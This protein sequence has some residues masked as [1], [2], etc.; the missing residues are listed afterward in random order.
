MR[1]KALT[2]VETLREQGFKAYWAGGCVRDL[3]MG[4]EPQDYDIATDAST[5]QIRQIFPKTVPVGAQFGVVIVLMEGDE[6]QVATF[7]GKDPD[8]AQPGGSLFAIH[9]VSPE[10]PWKSE[11]ALDVSL[12]DFTINGLLYD[13]LREKISDFVRGQ[14]D[15]RKG[16]VRAIGDPYAR[17]EEDKLRPMRGVRLAARYR[18]RIEEKTYEAMR[19]YA[20]KILQVSSERVRDEL[21][22]ILTEGHA[23]R[24]IELLQK[25]GL[26]RH[27]LPEVEAMVGVQQPPEHH[28][29]GDVF[30]HTLLALQEL[31]RGAEGPRGKGARGSS[32]PLLPS[33]SAPPPRV[34][35]AMAVLLHDVGK[36][37]TYQENDRITFKGHDKIGAEVALQVCQRLRFS[38][39][40]AERIEALVRD[41][42]KFIQIQQMRPNKLKRFLRQEGF[43]EHLE[44]HRLDCLASHRNLENWE[45]CV[46]KLQELSAEQ[47]H[48]P[49]LIT[50][51]D[52]IRLGY[53]PGPIFAEVLDYIEDAQ[54]EERI[55][56]RE[57]ALR[58]ATEYLA[59]NSSKLKA[60]GS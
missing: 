25:V 30:A 41:H 49:K 23:A 46:G 29:E 18:F 47:I 57:E 20:P 6:F 59:Q 17:F 35:L 44:L 15:I 27:I 5:E 7:R 11:E 36:P 52:L 48:P 58:M 54:L 51:D 37:L 16:L 39:R 10:R 26:L 9:S 40:E 3:V 24:G 14:E 21:V 43:E 12:R 22:R 2:I 4:L 56:T 31:S 33:S 45:F 28:P 1:E 38:R 13:P 32:A 60:Q 50:G 19:G 34:E 8:K 55:S 42:L 53:V